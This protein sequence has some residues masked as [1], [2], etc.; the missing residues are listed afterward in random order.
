MSLD[1]ANVNLQLRP[2]RH[3]DLDAASID[4]SVDPDRFAEFQRVTGS[5]LQFGLRKGLSLHVFDLSCAERWTNATRTEPCFVVVILTDGAGH[6]LLSSPSGKRPVRVEYS[7]GTTMY[8]LARTALD[9]K[10]E[11]PVGSRMR[12]VELRLTLEHLRRLDVLH[13]LSVLDAFHPFCKFA[14]AFVWTGS[15]PTS[16]TS[17]DRANAILAAALGGKGSD[18]GIEISALTLLNDALAELEAWADAVSPR[19]RIRFERIE[20]AARILLDD[21]AASWTVRDLAQAVGLSESQLK[22]GFRKQFGSPV[23]EYLQ[24]ARLEKA[25]GLLAA[26]EASV[27]DVALAVGYANPSHFAYLFRRAYGVPPSGRI[28]KPRPGHFAL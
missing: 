24:T 9:A 1:N 2:L 7:A 5:V 12:G 26:G 11:V 13:N 17:R 14:D 19:Q 25:K 4:T 16:P 20:A 15:K 10:F 28:G 8:F 3:V 18:L 27:T 21:L 22:A 6:G 23:Y